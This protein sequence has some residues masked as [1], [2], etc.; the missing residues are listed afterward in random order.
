MDTTRIEKDGPGYDAT[1]DYLFTNPSLG[2]QVIEFTGEV[3]P[4][5]NYMGIITNYDANQ[6]ASQLDW[7][8]LTHE[9]EPIECKCFRFYCDYHYST[10]ITEMELYCETEDVGSNLVGGMSVIYSYYDDLWWSPSLTQVSDT[11]VN[12][13]VGDTPRYFRIE[14]EPITETTLNNII[15]NVKNEAFYVGRKGCEY[16]ILPVNTKIGSINKAKK[17]D[18]K[19]IYENEF[20]LYVDIADDE[21]VEDRLIYYSTMTSEESIT[22]PEVGPDTKYYDAEDYPVV[23][24]NRNCAINCDCW[25]L[26]NLIDGKKAYYS[27]DNGYTWNEFGTLASGVSINFSNITVGNF[28]L[29]NIPVYYRDRYWKIGWLCEDHI[30]M[31]VREMV[32]FYNGEELTCTFYHDKE[33][34]FEDGP[35]SDTAPH[36][37]N[38]SITS[39]YYKLQGGTH[40]GMDLSSQKEID[41]ILWFHDSINDYDQQYCGIDKYTELNLTV[42][43]SNIVDYSYDERNFTIG[44]GIIIGHGKWDFDYNKVAIANGLFNSSDTVPTSGTLG[45]KPELVDDVLWDYGNGITLTTNHSLGVDLGSPKEITRIRFYLNI[46][47]EYTGLSWRYSDNNW[48]VYSSNDNSSWTLCYQMTNSNPP[49]QVQDNSWEFYSEFVFPVNQTARYF[50]LWCEEPMYVYASQSLSNIPTCSEIKVFSEI[51]NSYKTGIEFQGDH[52]SYITVPASSDF[53]FPGTSSASYGTLAK[54]FTV[55]FHVKFNDV[56]V[57]SGTDYCTLIRNWA[58]PVT[59]VKYGDISF[60]PENWMGNYIMEQ[61][62]V[63]SPDVNYAIFVRSVYNVARLEGTSYSYSHLYRSDITDLFD[64]DLHLS[65][66]S[67]NAFPFYVQCTLPEAK[68]VNKYGIRTYFSTTTSRKLRSW[69]FQGY[70]TASGTW[71]DLHSVSDFNAWPGDRAE[72]WEF[73]NPYDACTQYRLNATANWGA[74]ETYLYEIEMYDEYEGINPSLYQLEFWIQS[75]NPGTYA[76]GTQHQWSRNL[77]PVVANGSYHICL[78]RDVVDDGYYVRAYV[79]GDLCSN[80]YNNLQTLPMGMNYH[81]EDLIIGEGLNGVIS[82]LRITKDLCRNDYPS[83]LWHV[84]ERFY[85]MSIYSSVDNILYGKYCD[86]DLYK[87]NSYSLYDS[88]GVFSSNYYSQ[89]AID[90]ENRYDLEL[91]RSYGNSDTQPFSIWAENSMDI[92]YSND[93]L[94]DVAQITWSTRD[95]YANTKTLYSSEIYAGNSSLPGY[96]SVIKSFTAVDCTGLTKANGMLAIDIKIS[97]ADSSYL[98][99]EIPGQIE[100]TSAGTYDSEE[101]HYVL[102]NADL[103]RLTTEY[104]TFYFL[105]RDFITTGGE[106]DVSQ[107]NYIRVYVYSKHTQYNLYLYWKN[108]KVMWSVPDAIIVADDVRWLRFDLLNGD[109]TSRIIRKLGIYPDISTQLSPAGG[110]YNHEWNYLGKSITAYGSSTNLALEA[111]ISGSSYFGVM[112][113]D[114]IVNGEINLSNLDE[115]IIA[116]FY[117]V[118]GS[119]GESSPW[120]CIDLGNVYN[121]YRVKIYHGYDDIDT[122]YL[123]TDYT[124]QTS[125]D[126]ENFITRF[127]ISGND[128]FIRVHDLTNSVQARYVKIIIT[129]YNYKKI[130]LRTD[131]VQGSSEFFSGAVLREV[132]VYEYYGYP[133]IDSE[134]YPVVAINLGDQFYLSTHSIIGM[135]I[136][137]VST[138]WC[139]ENYNFCYSDSILSNPSKVDFREWNGNP[140]YDQWAVVKMDTAENYRNGPHYLK[141]VRIQNSY[142]QNPCNYPWWWQSNISTISRDYN[143]PLENSIS[144]LKIEYP[145]STSVE[146]IMFIEGD[147]FGTDTEAS[148]RDGFSFRIRFDDIDNLD[149]SYGYFY[150]GGYDASSGANPIIYKWYINTISGSLNSGWS[151]IFFRF[152]QADEIEYI[153]TQEKISDVRIAS[154]I[155]FSTIGMVFKGIGN[156]LTINLDGFKIE[157]NRFYDYGAHGKGCYI[158]NDDFITAPIGEFNLSKGTIEFWIRTDYN[159]YGCDYYNV[160]KNRT[161]FHFNSNSNDVLGMMVTYKGLEIYCGSVDKPLTVYSLEDFGMDILDSLLHFGFVFSNDGTQ[162]SNDGSTIRFYVNNYLSFKTTD[163]WRVYDNK[164]FSFILGGKGSL[165]LKADTLVT[166]SSVDAV[167]S[168]FK[169]YNYC[170]TDFRQS[171]LS[172]T[173]PADLLIKPSNF[174]EISKDKNNLTYYK[175]G[176]NSLPLK[177]AD[178]PPGDTASVYVRTILPDNLSGF[179]NRTARLLIYFDISI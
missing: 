50:K 122:D 101:W 132:E 5:G 60:P 174:I 172:N 93:N 151:R 29:I 161:L 137:T 166:T 153:D 105:L 84:N 154:T 62:G 118:W 94:D 3:S 157:R 128:E 48:Y 127:S 169:I 27:N 175:V 110:H 88:N 168:D 162:I 134:E 11:I 176:D 139:N 104:Q 65:Y 72:Y 140:Y 42:K 52:S 13:F 150:F 145:A 130:L 146:N 59:T 70:I 30:A 35:I 108:A 124:I 4:D 83:N 143:Y 111:T 17:I 103:G 28:S 133:K 167:I 109:G 91:I 92:Y 15:F 126:G 66:C 112:V 31:N 10:K 155:N 117:D 156:P 87:E 7:N 149:K 22:N 85:T 131:Y 68:K 89:L 114:K 14:I 102:Y 125:T 58:D 67:F 54:S 71:I 56:P 25:G 98:S 90:L 148:W 12:V 57:V 44:P 179:E 129:D 97:P 165:N 116:S 99:L 36:L 79:N 61:G 82:D 100:I 147:D 121:I 69:T 40:I 113:P 119:D 74:S 38:N 159:N 164:H 106:L 123:V 16:N 170:K 2:E 18:I 178:V 49:L 115:S 1:K 55:D 96:V 171:M 160:F 6:Q 107:I 26:K 77:F 8:I 46:T 80:P 63:G 51:P 9:F 39:S 86:I 73:T 163:T 138:D 76:G 158:N 120:I 37:R 64:G 142:D 21:E 32:P 78:R 81:C 19:N 141:H 177:Y 53:T 47:N 34:P 23:N 135:D 41:K 45:N 75:Y 43:D 33:L 152:K 173:D 20:D 144:S 95:S 24:Y 136:N